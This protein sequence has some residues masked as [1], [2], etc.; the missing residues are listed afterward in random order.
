M[1][2]ML[3]N[4]YF[5]ARRYADAL[6]HLEDE[7]RRNPSNFPVQ[8]KLIICYLQT[9][10]IENAIDLFHSVIE[11]DVDYIINTDP[12]R[13]DCPC[14]DIIQAISKD[15]QCPTEDENNIKLGIL[16]LY[17]DLE[18]SINHFK[19]VSRENKFINKIDEILKILTIRKFQPN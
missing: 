5:L 10:H 6:L 12:V 19:Q 4:Q 8:K 13:D 1:S 9:G 11:K 17:C 3:G 2:E 18:D 14:P 7:L 15:I 16:W